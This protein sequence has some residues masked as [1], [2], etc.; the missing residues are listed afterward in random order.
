VYHAGSI[1]AF[2]GGAWGYA[3][4]YLTTAATTRLATR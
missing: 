3:N 1:Y 2:G 4:D